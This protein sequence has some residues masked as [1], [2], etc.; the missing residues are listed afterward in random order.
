Y[1][2]I[3]CWHKNSV[4]SEAMWRLYCP[5]NT[6]SVAIKTNAAKLWAETSGEPSVIVGRVH[7]IDYSKRFSDIQDRLFCKRLSL[8]YE[9]E[10]RAII[11]APDDISAKG[12]I[13]KCDLNNL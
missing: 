13:V 8:S 7:Y 2:Y 1:R 9:S 6:P 12:R 10:V 3:S 4:E 11:M 5:P